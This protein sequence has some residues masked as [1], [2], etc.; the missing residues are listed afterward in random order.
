MYHSIHVLCMCNA[1][2]AEGLT[3]SSYFHFVILLYRYDN[4]IRTEYLV[5]CTSDELAFFNVTTLNMQG[6]EDCQD[7][8]GN[9][10]LNFVCIRM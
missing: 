10:R 1:S 2:T 7:E 9:F 3:W 4:Q 5:Q 6:S 8:D